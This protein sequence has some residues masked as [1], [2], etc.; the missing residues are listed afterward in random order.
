MSRTAARYFPAVSETA[1]L[2]SGVGGLKLLKNPDAL[3]CVRM[4]AE[5]GAEAIEETLMELLWMD[6]E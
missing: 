4:S 2:S 5:E 3:L 6:D 1:S